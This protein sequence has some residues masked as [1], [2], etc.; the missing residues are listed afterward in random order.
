[1]PLMAPSAAAVLDPA[2]R[3]V[4]LT[5]ARWQ[6]IVNGHP[7]LAPHRDAV[8]RTVQR[9][10]RQRAGRR[11]AEVWYYLAGAGPSR[12]LKVVVAY[13]QEQGRI[14]TAFGRRSMP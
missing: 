14:I 10:T 1:M 4:V 13:E 8:L 9:P 7:E 11:A 6:H 3:P 12:W 2:G 5:A